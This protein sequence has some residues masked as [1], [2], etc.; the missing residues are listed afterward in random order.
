MGS[1]EMTVNVIPGFEI[2]VQ[3]D[4]PET[5][6]G[7]LEIMP[8]GNTRILKEAQVESFIEKLG[9][10]GVMTAVQGTPYAVLYDE[11]NMVQLDEMMLLVGSMLVFR[12]GT[13]CYAGMTKRD[14]VRARVMLSSLMIMLSADGQDVPAFRLA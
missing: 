7:V 10:H 12:D 5:V 13:N 2:V 4:T 11:R 1:F 9:M 14:A 3:N 8:T 6:V